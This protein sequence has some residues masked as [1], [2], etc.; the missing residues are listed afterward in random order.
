MLRKKPPPRKKKEVRLFAFRFMPLRKLMPQILAWGPLA[1]QH[2]TLPFTLQVVVAPPVPPVD[3]AN[4]RAELLANMGAMTGFFA[5]FAEVHN[6]DGLAD[7][8]GH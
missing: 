6:P 5:Q 1:H 4:Y 2:L 8:L 3:S 7:V